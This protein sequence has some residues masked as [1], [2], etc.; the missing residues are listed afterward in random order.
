MSAAREEG[1]PGA[2]LRGRGVAAFPAAAA[3]AWAALG[4]RGRA[5]GCAQAEGGGGG[6]RPDRREGQGKLSA[7]RRAAPVAKPPLPAPALWCTSLSFSL[8]HSLTSW[9]EIPTDVERVDRQTDTRAQGAGAGGGVAAGGGE[10]P[11]SGATV[12]PRPGPACRVGARPPEPLRGAGEGRALGGRD[13]GVPRRRSRSREASSGRGRPLRAPAGPSLPE[14][15]EAR[16]RRPCGC[17]E[18]SGPEPLRTGPSIW[19]G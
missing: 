5:G 19:R 13:A 10:S 3:P 1:A 18:S 17:P 4:S 7:R 16:R 2:G 14:K 11:H 6:E 15:R 8:A 12:R 9:L